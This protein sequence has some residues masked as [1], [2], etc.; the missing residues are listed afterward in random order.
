MIKRL[1]EVINEVI[2]FMI[3]LSAHCVYKMKMLVLLVI[4]SPEFKDIQFNIMSY[5]IKLLLPSAQQRI[6]EGS[7][8]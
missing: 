6:R 4:N 3:H 8:E 5:D 1:T 7:Q 2:I